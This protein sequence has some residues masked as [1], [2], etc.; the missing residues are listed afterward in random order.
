MDRGEYHQ[1]SKTPALSTLDNQYWSNRYLSHDTGW[2]TGC[3]TAP[4]K[5]YIDQLENKNISILI[6]G[7]GNSYE[8]EY[9]LQQGFADITLIDI[10]STLCERLRVQFAAAL[11]KGLQIICA[12]FFEHAGQYDLIIEQTFFCALEPSLRAS[13]AHKMQQLLKPGGKLV[14]LLFSKQFTG[15]PP[16][17]GDQ[18]E[19]RGLFQP[20]FDIEVMEPC[21]NS[22]K[23]REGAEL[24]IKL[25]KL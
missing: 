10:S 25:L 12:D 15:G 8:A 9:L 20:Y 17:G 13:Y 5:D 3:I 14:G 22:I 6:P 11:S 23:P 24:F 16:F 2:D 21:Y 18:A 19:Y 4:L 7:C 1:Q